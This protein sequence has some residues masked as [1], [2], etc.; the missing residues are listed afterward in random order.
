VSGSV[1]AVNLGVRCKDC[2]LYTGAKAEHAK[3]ACPASTRQWAGHLKHRAILAEREAAHVPRRRRRGWKVTPLVPGAV[4]QFD[5]AAQ[6]YRA[7]ELVYAMTAFYERKA[8]ELKQRREREKFFAAYRA[9]LVERG[10]LRPA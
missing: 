6:Y 5:L 4:S 7:K 2:L 1:T 9:S 3:S 8:F 10:L